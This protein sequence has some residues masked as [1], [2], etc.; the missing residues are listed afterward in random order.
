MC[1]QWGSLVADH[2]VLTLLYIEAGKLR[3]TFTMVKAETT[4]RVQTHALVFSLGQK[5]L[6]VQTAATWDKACSGPL[7]S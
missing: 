1:P 6:K 5:L 4:T 7:S 3:P 2:L